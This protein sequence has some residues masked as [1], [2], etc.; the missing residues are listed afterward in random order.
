MKIQ[1]QVDEHILREGLANLERGWEAVGGKLFLTN[2]R[3]YFQSHSVNLQTGSTEI[4]IQDIKTITPCWTKF[5]GRIPLFPNSLSV[6]TQSG[7]EYR[8]VLNRRLEWAAEVNREIAK[9]RV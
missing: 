1:L 3:L 7:A 9:A 8:F 2:H 5:L 6:G 4:L